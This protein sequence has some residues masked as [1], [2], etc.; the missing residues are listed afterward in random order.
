VG[1]WNAA[2]KVTSRVGTQVGFA[3]GRVISDGIGSAGLPAS[4]GSLSNVDQS[5]LKF[6]A[7][8]AFASAKLVCLSND[9]LVKGDSVAADAMVTQIAIARQM[10]SAILQ[11]FITPSIFPLRNHALLVLE[12]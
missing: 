8:A 1:F 2:G 4:D 7:A 6:A 5:V 3:V 9:V 10:M 12:S 11:M